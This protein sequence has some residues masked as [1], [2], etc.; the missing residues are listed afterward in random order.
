MVEQELNALPFID[1]HTHLFMPSLGHIGLWGIDEL[2]K[3]HY[4]E[5]ELFRFSP[6]TPAQYFALSKIA[7]ADLIW[8]TLFV[9]NTPVSEAARGVIAVLK[10]FGLPTTGDLREAR[11]FFASRKIEDHIKDVFRLAGISEAVMTNDPL[12]PEEAPVWE[13]G[14]ARDPQF[15]AVLRLDRIL[16]KWEQHWQILRDKGYDVAADGSGKSASEVR[17]FLATWCERMR[18]T[19]TVARSASSERRAG[20]PASVPGLRLRQ[21]PSGCRRSPPS[22][23]ARPARWRRCWSSRCCRAQA[24]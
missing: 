13:R 11:A 24:E 21:R 1:I 15:H 18:P 9:E 12:D 23:S 2:I 10:A 3:Y 4:L 20:S 6:V 19:A 8:K 14:A 5:A 17:R 22:S 16:N 7:K